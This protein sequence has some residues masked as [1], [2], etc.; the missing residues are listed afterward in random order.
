MCIPLFACVI[1][2]AYPESFIRGGPNLTKFDFSVAEEKRIQI[3]LKA[4][5]HRSDSEK[6]F[7]CRFAGEPVV[8]QH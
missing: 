2:H 7:K 5:H 4:G 6:P 3:P 1:A 8:A